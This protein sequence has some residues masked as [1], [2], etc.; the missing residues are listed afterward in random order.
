MLVQINCSHHFLRL[1]MAKYTKYISKKPTNVKY[2]FNETGFIYFF[3][4]SP[5][6]PANLQ[7]SSQCNLPSSSLVTL[8]WD[9]PSTG[10]GVTVSYD[11]TVSPTPLSG[12]PP[13]LTNTSI[14]L[15]LN[16]NTVYNVS[17]IAS[18]CGGPS[19]P[20]LFTVPPI[21]ELMK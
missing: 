12:S 1:I 3:I 2:Y 16:Y 14:Q 18:T 9:P 19:E 8:Q 4:G 7:L 21:G 10:G 11:L 20:A 6:P 5:S 15:S 17:I 13:S